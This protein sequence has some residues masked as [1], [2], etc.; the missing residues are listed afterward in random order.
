MLDDFSKDLAGVEEQESSAVKIYEELMAAKKKE[1]DTHSAA[2][3]KKH[4]LIGE[5]SVNIA[6]M[7]NDLTDSEEAKIEDT[8]FLQDLEKNCG[9]KEKEWDERCKTRNEELL[10]I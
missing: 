1:V 10:A 9:L 8:K 6:M 3:E 2:I 5:L 4:I 7:K